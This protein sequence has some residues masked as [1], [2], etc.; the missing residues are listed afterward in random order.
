MRQLRHCRCEGN[1]SQNWTDGRKW[2]DISADWEE[3]RSTDTEK[4]SAEQREEKST[5]LS[6]DKVVKPAEDESAEEKKGESADALVDMNKE[7]REDQSA[8]GPD[9]KEIA[10][11]DEADK[12]TLAPQ[13]LEED[14]STKALDITKIGA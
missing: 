5:D 12:S 3:E 7:D 13:L 6:I 1:L 14:K 9:E 8:E 11:A 4:K 2:A 10:N